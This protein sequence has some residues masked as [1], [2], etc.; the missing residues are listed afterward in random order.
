MPTHLI[1]TCPVCAGLDDYRQMLQGYL[2]DRCARVLTPVISAMLFRIQSHLKACA[3]QCIWTEATLE[4]HEDA[5][6]L[7]TQIWSELNAHK[8]YLEYVLHPHSV[9]KESGINLTA[10]RAYLE[11]NGIMPLRNPEASDSVYAAA[12][13]KYLNLCQREGLSHIVER[14]IAVVEQEQ[15][16][17][18]GVPF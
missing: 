15:P 13:D 9:L 3:G 6:A 4:L 17:L 1:D 18:A 8:L 7:L 11:A 2:K 16:E 5:S 12:L 10:M 14:W